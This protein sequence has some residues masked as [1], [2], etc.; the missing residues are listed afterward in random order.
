MCGCSLQLTVRHDQTELKYFIIKNVPV[1]LMGTCRLNV[2]SSFVIWLKW[3]CRYEVALVR[4]KLRRRTSYESRPICR[5]SP[6]ITHQLA[7]ESIHAL[8]FAVHGLLY[9]S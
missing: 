1:L 4:I 8:Q 9:S 3:I 7:L 6:G 5:E 2:R